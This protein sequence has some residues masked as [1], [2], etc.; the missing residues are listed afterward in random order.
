MFWSCLPCLEPREEMLAIHCGSL[1]AR[2]WERLQMCTPEPSV[3]SRASG[4]GPR[5]GTGLWR[6]CKCVKLSSSS[7]N[8]RKRRSSRSMGTHSDLGS[9]PS[10]PEI[11]VSGAVHGKVQCHPGHRRSVPSPTSGKCCSKLQPD[12]ATGEQQILASRSQNK[13]LQ[14]YWKCNY[15]SN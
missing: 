11:C 10:A 12:G 13:G 2:A 15:Q 14:H 8:R 9:V 4:L 6:E 3:L 1:Q 5:Q 7:F